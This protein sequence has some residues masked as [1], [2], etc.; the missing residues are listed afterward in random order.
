MG[1]P[2]SL[3]D[4]FQVVVIDRISRSS[5]LNTEGLG[6]TETYRKGISYNLRRFHDDLHSRLVTD[7]NRPTS[8]HDLFRLSAKYIEL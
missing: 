3:R 4:L 1:L 2:P 7:P 5:L 8:C 6:G